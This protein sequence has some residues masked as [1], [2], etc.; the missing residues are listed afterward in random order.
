MY[1]DKFEEAIYVL[2]CFQKTQVTGK[3]DR[4]LPRLAIAPWST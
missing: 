1:V 2:H 4:Q 3:Q